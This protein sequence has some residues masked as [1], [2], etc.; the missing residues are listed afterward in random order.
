MPKKIALCLVLC[1]CVAF[2][3]CSACRKQTAKTDDPVQKAVD[4]T[5]C[6]V[7]Q[8]DQWIRKNMW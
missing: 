2:A 6:A 5:A 1:Y 4:C 8:T 3:G 7:E